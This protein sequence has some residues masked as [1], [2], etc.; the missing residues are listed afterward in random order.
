[1]ERHHHTTKDMLPPHH[2]PW[3]T[4]DL[5]L[6]KEYEIRSVGIQLITWVMTKQRRAP[7]GAGF[8]PLASPFTSSRFSMSLAHA[9]DSCWHTH[10]L[11]T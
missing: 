8:L 3:Y 9:T 10:H 4:V 7:H 11:T 2:S 5:E 1:M 6:V